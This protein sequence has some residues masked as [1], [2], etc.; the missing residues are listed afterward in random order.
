MTPN[1]G[2]EVKGLEYRGLLVYR[3]LQGHKGLLVHKVLLAHRG[4]L[5][6]KVN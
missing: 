4:L 1:R 2:L 5:V 6:H 3:V